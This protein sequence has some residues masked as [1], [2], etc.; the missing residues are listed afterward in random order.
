MLSAMRYAV[1]ADIHGNLTAFQAVLRDIEQHGGMDEIWCLGDVVG[2]GAQ[3]EECIQLLRQHKHVCV[4]GNHDLAAIARID[5]ADF[6]PDAAA[7]ARWTADQLDPDSVAYLD[8]LP[9]TLERG[10]FTLV[11]GSPRYPA[12]EYLL[13]E[14]S[15]QENL[16]YFQTRCCFIGHS[17]IPL[18]FVCSA[19]GVCSLSELG[20][21]TRLGGNG[22]RLIINPGGVGQPRD[23]DSRASYAIYDSDSSVLHHYR[24]PYDIGAVQR[25]MTEVGLPPQL[26]MRLSYGW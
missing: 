23:G 13:S 4:A 19:S 17:H 21:D 12:W 24:V 14:I 18:R 16:P 22:C 8:S 1:L 15:A 2:Y 20:A 5:I 10:D 11:H 6:N 7:A 26:A 9:L 3:P 25:K